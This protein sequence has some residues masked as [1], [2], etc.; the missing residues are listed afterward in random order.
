MIH[1]KYV[2]NKPIISGNHMHYLS[3]ILALIG[4]ILSCYHFSEDRTHQMSIYCNPSL[5]NEPNVCVQLCSFN[6]IPHSPDS[7]MQITL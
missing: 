2:D 6:K 7:T 1:S 4:S 5:L 3:K